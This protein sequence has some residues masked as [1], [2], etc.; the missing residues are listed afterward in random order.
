ML[1]KKKR[2][3]EKRTERLAKVQSKIENITLRQKEEL[4]SSQ[5]LQDK[6]LGY[7]TLSPKSM[8]KKDF[9][10]TVN[11]KNLGLKK[12]RQILNNAHK[13]Q[14]IFKN[15]SDYLDKR[16]TSK[17]MHKDIENLEDFLFQVK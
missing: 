15:C 10:L 12:S 6:S 13:T 16:H 8:N 11:Q 4:G 14:K 7:A 17:S 2:T 9:N 5:A 3:F 1:E